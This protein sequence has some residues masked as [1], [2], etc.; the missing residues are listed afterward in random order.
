LI[1]DAERESF[2]IWLFINWVGIA[3]LNLF[4]KFDS[5]SSEE[6][7]KAFLG[8]PIVAFQGMVDDIRANFR[9]FECCFSFS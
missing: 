5:K 3:S 1:K 9:G 2:A 6:S 7:M 8:D 4:T